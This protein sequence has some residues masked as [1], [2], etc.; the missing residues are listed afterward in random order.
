VFNASLG[1]P[2][3]PINDQGRNQCKAAFIVEEEWFRN[4]ISSLEMV[5]DMQYVPVILDW[6]MYYGTDIP[7]D[8]KNSDAKSCSR[9]S[10]TWGLSTV[11]YSN[12]T[13]CWCF[14]GYDGNPYLPD[15]CTGMIRTRLM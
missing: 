7:E 10:T 5:K 6:D 11:T 15:G 4:N 8:V 12:S 14:S 13:T 3:H 1:T 2:E 9:G